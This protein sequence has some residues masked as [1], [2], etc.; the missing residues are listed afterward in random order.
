MKNQDKDSGLI[1]LS[2]YMIY[3]IYY[4]IH[5]FF[6]KRLFTCV[7]CSLVVPWVSANARFLLHNT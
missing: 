2:N 5:T 1:T 3:Y 6:L 4:R 7:L